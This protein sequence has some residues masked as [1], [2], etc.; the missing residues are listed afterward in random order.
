MAAVVGKP[1]RRI[2]SVDTRRLLPRVFSKRAEKS[3]S[4]SSLLLINRNKRAVSIDATVSTSTAT[5]NYYCH[6][7]NNSNAATNLKSSLRSPIPIETT[8]DT[9]TKEEEEDKEN[10]K[11]RVSFVTVTIREHARD[12]DIHPSVSCGPAM[13][14]GWSYQDHPLPYDFH[15][16]EDTK[17]PP[18]SRAEFQMPSAVRQQLL[19][20]HGVSPK[21]ISSA[22]RLNNVVRRQRAAT[23]AAQEVEEVTIAV[24]WMQRKMKKVLKRRHSYKKEEKQLWVDAQKRR[25]ASDSNIVT[26]VKLLDDESKH[27]E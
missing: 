13:G 9:T 7:N 24:E 16:F 21:D 17:P 22:V 2:P 18:R 26:V 4:N 14:L 20:D 3:K 1:P 23:M 6:G 15:D 19:E 27:A 11:K 10:T 12:V 5:M 25:A 8:T